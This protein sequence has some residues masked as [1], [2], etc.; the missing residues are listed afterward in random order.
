MP[1]LAATA[2]QAQGGLE[3]RGGGVGGWGGRRL[4]NRG[5]WISD[6]CGKNGMDGCEVV[7]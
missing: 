2:Q 1:R 4:R 7:G 5:D 6:G 3:A